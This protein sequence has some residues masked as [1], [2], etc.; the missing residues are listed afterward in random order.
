MDA[1][2]QECRPTGKLFYHPVQCPVTIKLVLHCS[3]SKETLLMYLTLALAF[4][5]TY[6]EVI[7]TGQQLTIPK[8][9]D[10][11]CSSHLFV[12]VTEVMKSLDF[13]TC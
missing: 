12:T 1:M 10:Y 9:H 13:N 8:T 2:M 3:C 11:H 4:F 7:S 5:S 6:K